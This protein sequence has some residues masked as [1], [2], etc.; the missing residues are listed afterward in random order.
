[1]LEAR[2]RGL[3][4]VAMTVELALARLDAPDGDDQPP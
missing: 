3:D 2:D 1:V 4:L